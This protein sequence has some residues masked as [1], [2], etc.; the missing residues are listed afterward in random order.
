MEQGEARVPAQRGDRT[1]P[2]P[3][4][5]LHHH[6]RV[7]CQVPDND[8]WQRRAVRITQND[9]GAAKVWLGWRRVPFEQL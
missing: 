3:A 8:L 5:R 6:D 9:P 7:P 1:E 2:S 4:D